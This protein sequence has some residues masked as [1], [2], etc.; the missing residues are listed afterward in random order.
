MLGK[1]GRTLLHQQAYDAGTQVGNLL[2][3]VG[4]AT[5]VFTQVGLA[6]VVKEAEQQVDG[7]VGADDFE[8]VTVLDVHNLVADVVGRLDDIDEGM[9]AVAIVVKTDEAQL[10]GNAAEDIF[11][12]SEKAEL[13]LLAGIH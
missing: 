4:N 2:V 8:F 12:G 13:A 3:G 5:H 9:T 7:L 10:V 11:L 1:G 6:L